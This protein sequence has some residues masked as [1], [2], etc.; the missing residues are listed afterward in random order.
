MLRDVYYNEISAFASGWLRNL[1]ASGHIHRGNVDT[2]SI[3]DVHPNDLT[4]FHQCHF[5]AGIGGWSYALRLSG[6]PDDLPV[7]TGSC[8]CQPFS[9]AGKRKGFK[10]ERHLW[11]AWFRLIEQCKPPV[12]FGEQVASNDGYAWLDTVCADLEAAGYTV[13][14]VVIP[15]A[16]F[17]APNIR[18][19][20]YFVADANESRLERRNCKGM[21]ECTCECAIRAFGSSRRVADSDLH[22]DGNTEQRRH[23]KAGGIPKSDWTQ[24]VS[25]MEFGGT[26]AVIYKQQP[27]QTNGFWQD[28]DWLFCRDEKWR[29]VEPGTFPLVD[30]VPS[31]VGRLRSYGNAIVPQVAAGFI[32]AYLEW[33]F[34]I[35]KRRLIH[36]LS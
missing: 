22:Y 27:G 17:G 21:S 12:I 8:P 3:N 9:S 25:S 15:A 24:V 26:N 14:A 28:A 30:G 23:G 35:K 16:G 36:E 29:P 2:R 10:D 6:W 13:G 33:D 32:T 1:V 11:P 7:W 18:H 4:G 5:F 19:R 34:W 31:R 20:I